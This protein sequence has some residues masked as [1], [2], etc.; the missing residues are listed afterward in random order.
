MKIVSI[1]QSF[2]VDGILV[3]LREVWFV[4]DFLVDKDVEGRK[5]LFI[6]VNFILS[7]TKYQWIHKNYLKLPEVA[8]LS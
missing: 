4:R 3:R 7:T 5:K 6:V 2:E 1:E 8:L